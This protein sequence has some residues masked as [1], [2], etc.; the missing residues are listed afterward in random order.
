MAYADV[1]KKVYGERCEMCGWRKATN[2][3][4]HIDYQEHQEMENRIRKADKAG[5]VE[6]VKQLQTEALAQGWGFYKNGQLPKNDNPENLSVICPNDHREVHF[7]DVGK[8]IL[9]ALPPRKKLSESMI[10]ILGGL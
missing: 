6:L 8:K 2:D 4:H 1:A 9:E 7:Y 3:V 10:K 5:N